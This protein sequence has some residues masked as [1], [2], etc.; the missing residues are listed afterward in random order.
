[1]TP[2]DETEV[3]IDEIS[4]DG[5]GHEPC[6]CIAG[7]NGFCSAHCEAHADD[8]GGHAECGCGHAECEDAGIAAAGIRS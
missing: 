1:M 4:E 6:A 8:A 2:N 7:P 3:D 5:C